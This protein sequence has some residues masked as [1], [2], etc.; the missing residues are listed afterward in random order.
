[1]PSLIRKQKITCENCGT[2]T[3]RNNIVCHKKRCSVG[4]L[5]STQCPNFSTKSQIDLNY[6]IAKKQSAPK[7]DV[8]FKCKLCYPEFPNFVIQS[9]QDFT[10]YL[11][12]ETRYT[13][14]RLD[15][16][17]KIWMWNI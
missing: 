14:C 1:M 3:T 2:Q 7:L 15:Q 16:E 6:R 10:L 12:I 4:T 9:S 11:S 5:C 13:E 8:T 17:Q